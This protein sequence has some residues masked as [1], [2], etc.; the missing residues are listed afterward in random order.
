MGV[1]QSWP[2]RGGEEKMS[3]LLPGTETR[4]SCP[5]LVIWIQ[6]EKRTA[7]KLNYRRR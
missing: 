1:P 5:T 3:L 2:G 6:N 4:S 7:R